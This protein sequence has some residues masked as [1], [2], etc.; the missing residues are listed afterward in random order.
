LTGRSGGFRKEILGNQFKTSTQAA[1]LDVKEL[2]LVGASYIWCQHREFVK[3]E[4]TTPL[5]HPFFHSSVDIKLIWVS[6]QC[7]SEVMWCKPHQNSY[8]LNIDALLFPNRS[9]VSGA[10]IRKGK[11]EAVAY[12]NRCMWRL[13]NRFIHQMCKVIR[14]YEPDI[15]IM[16]KWHIIQI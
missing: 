2:V 10:I 16:V 1:I 6:S 11:G 15:L 7:G 3:E 5:E 14:M 13:V 9:G 8:K 12:S 4:T